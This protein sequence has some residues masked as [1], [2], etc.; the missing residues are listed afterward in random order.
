MHALMSSAGGMHSVLS[1]CGSLPALCAMLARPGENEA[2]KLVVEMLIKLCLFS[3]E[4]YCLAIKVCILPETRLTRR[5]RC[6]E[7]NCSHILK[8][9]RVACMSRHKGKGHRNRTAPWIRCVIDLCIMT[10]VGFAPCRRCWGGLHLRQSTHTSK[11][12]P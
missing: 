4:G 6:D 8:Y 9:Q 5:L 3:T 2:A 10:L 11:Q 7:P 12:H 1:T